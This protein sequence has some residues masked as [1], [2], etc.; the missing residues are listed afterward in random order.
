MTKSLDFQTAM[1]FVYGEPGPIAPGIVRVVARNPGP[2][3][4]KGTNTYLVGMTELAVIDPGPDDADHIAAVLRAAS[5]RPVSRILVTHAHRDHVDGAR[6]LQEATGAPIC[7][8][9]RAPGGPAP[10]LGPTARAAYVNHGFKPDLPLADGDT[11]SGKEWSFE[12]VHTPGHAPDH[13][14]F[15]LTK[16]RALFSGDHVMAWNTTVVGPPEGRM[17]EF[18]A[19]LE[20]LLA[21]R[22][23]TLY[24]PAHGERLLQ[25]RRT[26]KAYLLH[27]QWREETILTAIRSGAS[28][29]GTIVPAVYQNLDHKL[30]GAAA[31]SVLAH[32]EHLI[33][34]GLVACDGEPALNHRLGL[35]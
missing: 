1:D 34:K 29:I 11:V 31:L 33:E 16:R 32:V 18:L 17:A 19:S 5:G 9:P 14:C 7:A 21:R 6:R 26:V 10:G 27:R 8:F 20:K 30:A 22:G 12:A 15:A 35:A 23:E 24:L 13:L 28:S 2:L 3:T 4:F 25:P